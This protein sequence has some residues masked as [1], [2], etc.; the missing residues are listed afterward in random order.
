MDSMTSLNKKWQFVKRWKQACLIECKIE[1]VPEISAFRISSSSDNDFFMTPIPKI[2]FVLTVLLFCAFP[3]VAQ[4]FPPT[5]IAKMDAASY[6]QPLPDDRVVP[7]KVIAGDFAAYPDAA[8]GK[9]S[10]KRIT[11]IGRISAINNGNGE[12]K[13]LVVTM[14][15]PSGNLPAVRANFLYGSIPANS[16]IQIS[17]DG[18]SA[19]LVRRDRSGSILAQDPYLAVDQ[20]VAIKGDF[21]EVKVGDIVLTSCKL[22]PKR[23]Y[24]E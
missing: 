20:R 1:S 9:Y 4:D 24:K 2:F 6:L 12:N 13:V 7:L 23:K 15:D 14:Q 18:S 16:E 11:V 17:S 5:K 8:I 21:K 10:G 3:L 22:E 19:T